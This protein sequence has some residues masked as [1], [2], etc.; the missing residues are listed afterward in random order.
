M[1]WKPLPVSEFL[2]SVQIILSPNMIQYGEEDWQVI[3]VQDVR[4]S[5]IW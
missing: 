3:W 2:N 5:D 1:N 4:D